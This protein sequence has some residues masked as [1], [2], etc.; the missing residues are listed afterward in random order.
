MPA[1][2]KYYD[3]LGVSPNASET[4]IKKAYKKLAMQ[5]HPDKNSEEGAGD[6]F[7]DIC[8]AYEILSDPEKRQAYDRFGK[9]G[10]K[11]GGFGQGL[12]PRDIFSLM[13]G[14]DGSFFTFTIGGAGPSSDRKRPLRDDVIHKL[15]V[16]FEYLYTGTKKILSVQKNAICGFRDG[17]LGLGAMQQVQTACPSCQGEGIYIREKHRW[18]NCKEAKIINEK[19]VVE[20][21]IEKGAGGSRFGRQGNDLAAKVKVSL[22]EALCGFS[23]V[24]LTHLDSR[25][26]Y[27]EHPRGEV[28]RPGQ[29]R[30]ISGEGMPK[31]NLPPEKGDLFVK[32]DIE[33]PD[34]HWTKDESLKE[35]ENILPIQEAVLMEPELMSQCVLEDANL[36]GQDSRPRSSNA[37][38]SSEDEDSDEHIRIHGGIDCKQT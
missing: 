12:D 32:F 14:G 5:F 11:N 7:K 29:I 16:T 9:D 24:L 34:D 15:Q 21:N 33:F 27:V 35:L 20:V 26:I 8:H 19:K 36:E 23:K 28:I 6:K 2:T 25:G 30:R 31:R 38:K 17:R 1:D 18:K 22:T 4:E 13:F 3:A 10:P 37:Y